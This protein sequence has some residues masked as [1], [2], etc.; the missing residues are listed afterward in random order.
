MGSAESPLKATV[1]CALPERQI[2]RCLELP[3]GATVAVA[4]RCSRLQQE[5]PDMDFDSAAVGIFGKLADRS[6]VL[7]QGDRVEV[8]RPLRADPKESRRKR[9]ARR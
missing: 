7:Q 8:Y 5:F 4:L 9:S 3:R 2:E 1:I 6:T